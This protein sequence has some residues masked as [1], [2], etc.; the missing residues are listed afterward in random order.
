MNLKNLRNQKASLRWIPESLA[1]VHV[2]FHYCLDQTESLIPRFAEGASHAAVH[3]ML[4]KV[5]DFF[6]VRYGVLICS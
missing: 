4:D 6:F 1:C 2:R 5:Q 3:D